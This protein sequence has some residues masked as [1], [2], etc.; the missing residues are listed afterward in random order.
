MAGIGRTAKEI[1]DGDNQITP[2][3]MTS[4]P[5]HQAVEYSSGER[6]VHRELERRPWVLVDLFRHGW[7][8]VSHFSLGKEHEADFVV[9]HGW[10]GGW[11]IHF[12]ELE[13]PSLSPFNAKGDFSSRMNH[14][15][16][17]ILRWKQFNEHRDKRPY[18]VTQ[19]RQAVIAKDLLTSDGKEPTDSCGWPLTHPESVLLM[20]Y[21]VIMGRRQHLDS[22]FIARKAAVGMAI[23][24]ELI[25]YDRV[26]EVFDRQRIDVSYSTIY[27]ANEMTV[28]RE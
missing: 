20:H 18:L 26:L 23:G 9:L 8:I 27:P 21:H 19:L 12:V 16:G 14:A 2:C 4:T 1:R 17:Q 10:S 28:S 7:Y 13:P 15:A 22:T 6:T 24:F 11:D 3:P 5:L 25:T